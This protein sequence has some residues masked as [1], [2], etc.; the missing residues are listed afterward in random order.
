MHGIQQINLNFKFRYHCRSGI[1]RTVDCGIHSLF[2]TAL[3]MANELP[4]L[5]NEK[6]MYIDK[7]DKNGKILDTKFIN[8]NLNTVY[9]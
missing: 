9:E 5:E 4:G 1:E 3:K 8:K 7:L 2:S 6:I